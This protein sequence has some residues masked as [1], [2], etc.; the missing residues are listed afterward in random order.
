VHR[1]FDATDPV[2]IQTAA[3]AP[4]P[5]LAPSL[6]PSSA[7]APPQTPTPARVRGPSNY[8]TAALEQVLARVDCTDVNKFIADDAAVWTSFLS[9]QDGFVSK[10]TSVDPAE[11]LYSVDGTKKTSSMCTVRG[12]IVYGARFRAEIYTRGCH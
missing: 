3:L 9:Q 12:M 2:A 8:S 1:L 6:A 5:S 4:T 7:A 10:L 11:Y